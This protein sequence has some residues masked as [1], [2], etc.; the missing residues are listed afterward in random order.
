MF[1]VTGCGA[2]RRAADHVVP[3]S[4]DVVK[5]EGVV[6]TR[7]FFRRWHLVFAA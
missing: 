3:P 2:C 1:V 5:P 4:V 7:V 6:Q